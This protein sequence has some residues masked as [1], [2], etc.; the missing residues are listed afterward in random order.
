MEEE[1]EEEKAEVSTTSRVRVHLPTS[2]VLTPEG[3]VRFARS[4]PSGGIL[5]ME[6]GRVEEVAVEATAAAK[7]QKE[8]DDMMHRQ[9]DQVSKSDAR[10]VEP[11]CSRTQTTK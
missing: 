7:A 2:M 9:G 11:G 4:L 3:R 8:L 6:E 1:E 10:S 5:L